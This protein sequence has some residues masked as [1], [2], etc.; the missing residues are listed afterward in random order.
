[1]FVILVGLDPT[2]ALLSLAVAPFLY[3]SLRYYSKT[4]TDRAE[5]VKQKESTL[6]ERAYEILSSIAAIKSFARERHELERFSKVGEETMTARLR[7]TWQESLFSLCVTVITLGGHGARAGRRR[8]ARAAGH[9][10][11]GRP[12]GGDRLPGRGVWPAV[13]D[14]AHHRRAAAGARERPARA[15]DVRADARGARR[16]RR[17]RRLRHCRGRRVRGRE[18]RLRRE[19]PDPAGHQLRRQP[20]RDGRAGRPHRRRQDDDRQPDSA[21]LRADAVAAC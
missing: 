7:L 1:M 18:L 16:R 14:C 13:V 3:V 11:R 10:H 4:M 9:A 2:L 12:A 15:G 5:R 8:P 21:V 19:P 6:V 20:R 17:H